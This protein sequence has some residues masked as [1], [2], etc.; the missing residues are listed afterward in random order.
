M[1]TEVPAGRTAALSV[2]APGRA[3]AIDGSAYIP[4]L[5]EVPDPE[6][7]NAL[8]LSNTDVLEDLAQNAIVGTIMGQTAGSTLFLL[9]DA[10]DRFAIDGDDIV[11]GAT[12]LDFE[13]DT[14][15]SITI[16]ERLSGY[17]DLL[18]SIT[19]TVANV[20]EAPD[21]DTLAL[22][23]AQITQG[24]SATITITG[25]TAGSTITGTVPDGMTLNS[26]ARTITGTPTTVGD[27]QFTLTET[28][29]DSANSPK[30]NDVAIKVVAAQGSAVRVIMVPLAGQSNIHGRN[31]DDGQNVNRA[32]KYQFGAD[33][34]KAAT[35]QV[36]SND[37]LDL[38]HPENIEARIGPDDQILDDL[39]TN[40]P[41]AKI[42]GIPLGWGSSGILNGGW[43]S[44][45]TPGSGGPHF[46]RMVTQSN[47]ARDA[48]LAEFPNATIEWQFYW[49]QGEQDAAEG[50]TKTAYKSALSDLIDRARSRIT[51][52]DNAP[53]VI[54]S[55]VPEKFT[56]ESPT[57]YVASYVPINAAHVEL[58]IDKTNV[59]YVRGPDNGPA[60]DNL[61]YQPAGIARVFGSRM[62]ASQS[63]SV[64]PNVTNAVAQGANVGAKLSVN[65]THDDSQDSATFHITGGANAGLFE[66]SDPY[67]E[68]VLR[69]TGDG[70]GPAAGQ[71]VVQV[72]ARDGAGNYGPIRAFDITVAEAAGQAVEAAFRNYV[73]IGTSAFGGQTMAARTIRKGLN[74]FVLRMNGENKSSTMTVT[75]GGNAATRLMTNPGTNGTWE[76]WGYESAVDTTADVVY[77]WGSHSR[78]NAWFM[79]MSVVGVKPASADAEY[80]EYASHTPPF[81]TKAFTI[82]AAGGIILSFGEFAAVPTV[83][84]PSTKIGGGPNNIRIATTRATSGTVSYN[85]GAPGFR[86]IGSLVLEKS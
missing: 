14:D 84:D 62:A 41:D 42:V 74:V 7:L 22:S 15:H 73:D 52:A 85:P 63:D 1:P 76:I 79:Q 58:S 83:A 18:T 37:T 39:A 34:S 71:Y 80:L 31:E 16:R 61:H 69:W 5:P 24:Q 86:E 21:L 53:W 6:Q 75:V 35:Y 28:L 78:N 51:G 44:D 4:P 8:T 20:N 19:I 48:A 67:I 43:L 46:E 64:G 68:P 70:N 49:V 38:D 77:S 29:G 57:G 33:D 60:D 81:V 59:D 32:N 47:L 12:A 27:F 9:S 23:S 50:R 36:L 26:A 10:G 82:P 17:D 3:I 11:R 72:Q 54:G 30:A 25:A 56:P 13:S 40:N 55:M 45:A 2:N 66:I 65:L